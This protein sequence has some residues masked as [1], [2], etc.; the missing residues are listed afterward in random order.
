MD[1]HEYEVWLATGSQP[2]YWDETLN[3]VAEDSRT[4]ADGLT[5]SG[6]LP[7]KVIFKPVVT[8]PESIFELCTEANN[9]RG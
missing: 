7:V 3:K 5:R 8:T 9:T 6:K 2:L 4:I 1:F